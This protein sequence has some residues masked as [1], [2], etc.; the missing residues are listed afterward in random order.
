MIGISVEGMLRQ[1]VRNAHPTELFFNLFSPPVVPSE[2][3]I[4]AGE[5]GEEELERKLTRPQRTREREGDAVPD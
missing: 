3:A 5:I 1:L 4:K 2:E